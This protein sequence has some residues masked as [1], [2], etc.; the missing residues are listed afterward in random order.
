[1]ATERIVFLSQEILRIVSI[2]NAIPTQNRGQLV[3]IDQLAREM[4]FTDGEKIACAY[5][6][7][8]PIP[9]Q[10]QF[11]VQLG[12]E[13]PRA[14]T[15]AQCKRLLAYVQQP[16]PE[17]AWKRYDLPTYNALCEKLGGDAIGGDDDS[18]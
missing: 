15:Q 17:Y 4:D 14:L 13:C 1:M 11:T 5:T 7:S 3:A 18:E 16:P 10:F 2:L 9:G 6:V 8:E 12:V